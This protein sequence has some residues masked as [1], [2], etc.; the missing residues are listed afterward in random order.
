MQDDVLAVVGWYERFLG[1]I[2][3]SCKF[4]LFVDVSM[5][6]SEEDDDIYIYTRST[7]MCLKSARI[8][9]HMTLYFL[10]YYKTCR[11][12]W[13]LNKHRPIILANCASGRECSQHYTQTLLCCYATDILRFP[14]RTLVIIF[15]NIAKSLQS[16]V[17]KW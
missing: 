8:I 10:L 1:C 17:Q 2:R 6:T 4:I 3:V 12:T 16:K 9:K 13:V 14:F 7:S 15:A 11:Y 5:K